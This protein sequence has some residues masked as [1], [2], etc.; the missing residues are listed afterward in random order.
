ME[1]DTGSA[2]TIL[3]AS[4]FHAHFDQPLQPTSTML[5][6]YAG[7]R[8]RPM[9][10]FWAHVCYSG[11][12]FEAN[13]Y[14]VDSDGPALFG[15]DWPQNI[16]FDWHS[17]QYIIKA[18]ATSALLSDGT[19]R[20]LDV[21][22]SRYAAVFGSDRGHLQPS[23]GHLTLCDGAQPEF[24]KARPLPYALRDRVGL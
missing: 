3:P 16:V 9:G 22:R 23:R 17:L 5:K 11:E 2:L 1:L 8:L 20:R 10:A 19:C 18:N 21:L 24:S 15:R 12:E 6:P 13:A 7:D 4:M 14:V